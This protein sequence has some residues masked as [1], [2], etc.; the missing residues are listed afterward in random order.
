M[1]FHSIN[2]G[3]QFIFVVQCMLKCLHVILCYLNSFQLVSE[4]EWMTFELQ[5]LGHLFFSFSG[6]GSQFFFF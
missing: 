6:Y 1:A 4:L 2:Q 5:F 3:N